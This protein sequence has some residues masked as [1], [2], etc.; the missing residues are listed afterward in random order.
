MLYKP[1]SQYFTAVVNSCIPTL[2]H[3]LMSWVYPLKENPFY[4]RN[5]SPKI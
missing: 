2:P 1:F 4:F 3:I 5:A